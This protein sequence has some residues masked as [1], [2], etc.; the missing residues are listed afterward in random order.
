ML[1]AKRAEVDLMT[2]EITVALASALAGKAAEAA[3]DG[4]QGAWNALVRLVRERFTRDDAAAKVLDA[5]QAEPDDQAA[6]HKLRRALDRVAA[7]DPEF[8]EQVR[9]LW[10]LA[11]QELSALDGGVLNMSI[12]A[13][14]GH[15]IQARDLQVHGGLYLGDIGKPDV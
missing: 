11:S 1:C 12:G 5:A 8:A 9:A 13:V 4:V 3:V 10:P 6:V 15:L 2:D 14:S 7:V